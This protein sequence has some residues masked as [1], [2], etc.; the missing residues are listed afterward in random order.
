MRWQGVAGSTTVLGLAT[1][2]LYAPWI[3]GGWQEVRII[4]KQAYI[5][6]TYCCA[7]GARV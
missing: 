6:G 3:V 7:Q 4:M 5:G 1:V 2:V